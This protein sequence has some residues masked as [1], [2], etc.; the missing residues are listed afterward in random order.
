MHVIKIYHKQCAFKISITQ[1]Y[2]VLIGVI[3]KLS[4]NSLNGAINAV[5]FKHNR[6][7]TNLEKSIELESI[8]VIAN[9]QVKLKC[10]TDC[11]NDSAMFFLERSFLL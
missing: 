4:T 11:I 9:E 1:I 8:Y 6:F 5:Q 3:L 10:E 7:T 2:D